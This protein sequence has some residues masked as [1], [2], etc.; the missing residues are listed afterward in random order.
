MR[1][2]HIMILA[3]SMGIT[4]T[5]YCYAVGKQRQ[6]DSREL[7]LQDMLV[8]QLLPHMDEKLSEVYSNVLTVPPVLYPYFVDVKHT[9]RVNGFR[10]FDFLIT[11]DATPTVGP[12]IPVGEDLFTYQIS[13]FGVKLKKF[14]HVKGPNPNDFPPNYKDLLK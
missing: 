4:Q 12:H 13:P 2:I 6:E 5:S 7:Q 1:F 10:G 9:E 3:I 14:E 11:L 8:L